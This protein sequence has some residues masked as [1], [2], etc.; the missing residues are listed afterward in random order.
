MFGAYR[1]GTGG[2]GEAEERQRQRPH[3]SQHVGVRRTW[4]SILSEGSTV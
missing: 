4:D 1:E 2:G 3:H